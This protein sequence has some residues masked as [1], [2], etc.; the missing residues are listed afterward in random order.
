MTQ[1]SCQINIIAA[2][3]LGDA[4]SQSI[5]SYGINQVLP[6]YSSSS[7]A[8]VNSQDCYIFQD[9]VNHVERHC[10]IT[11]NI[12]KIITSQK[13]LERKSLLTL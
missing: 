12:L 7:I 9:L 6:E 5:S 11:K 1:F 4:R 8:R 13:K 3:D 2:D 10:L